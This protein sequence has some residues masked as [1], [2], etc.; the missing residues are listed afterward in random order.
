[1]HEYAIHVMGVLINEPVRLVLRSFADLEHLRYHEGGGPCDS[2]LVATRVGRVECGHDH[3]LVVDNCGFESAGSSPRT[4]VVWRYPS[5]SGPLAAATGEC[6]GD[7]E[8]N[9]D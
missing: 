6:F 8:I 3:Q 4:L 9:R 7:H 2:D 1:M 5:S